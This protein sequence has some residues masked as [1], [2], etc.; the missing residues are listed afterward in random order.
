[1]GDESTTVDVLSLEDF[2]TTIAARLDE[3]N[4]LLTT[5]NTTLHNARPALGGFQDAVDTA[6][7]YTDL[8]GEHAAGVQ[9]LIDAIT[10][11][12]TATTT[13]IH[14]YR[15]TEAR[16]E[17]NATDIANTLSPVGE[18]LNGGQPNAR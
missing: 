10:A 2:Q 17:A 16:N 7:R 12:Q 18:V 11:A 4:S 13:I 5:L 3:A 6:G 15:T 1:M 9:R 8:H 14:N